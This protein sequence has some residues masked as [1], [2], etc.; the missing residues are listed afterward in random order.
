MAVH[1]FHIFDR[2][3]KTLFTKRYVDRKNGTTANN[4]EEEQR[5]LI[6][7]MLFSLREL[8]TSLSPVEGPCDLELVNTGA[9]TLYNYETISGLRFV[10]YTTSSTTSTGATRHSNSNSNSNSNNSTPTTSSHGATSTKPMVHAPTS[11]GLTMA[12]TGSSMNTNNDSSVLH[13][14]SSSSSLHGSANVTSTRNPTQTAKIRLS[15]KYIYEHIW[16]GSVVRSPMYRPN[17]NDG[18]ND[19]IK[20]TNFESTLDNYLK[21]MTWFR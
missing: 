9:S 13:H 3:G 1:S 17:S 8:S 2:R 5:K 21:G 19:T 16:V 7:G 11:T 10:L 15:L 18:N 6:F 20:S 12:G 14:S 4:D